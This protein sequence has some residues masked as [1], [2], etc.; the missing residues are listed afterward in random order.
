M[1]LIVIHRSNDFSSIGKT[2]LLQSALSDSPIADI[3]LDGLSR[4]CL[5]K[6]DGEKTIL[7]PEEWENK[8]LQRQPSIASYGKTLAVDLK[9]AKKHN[10]NEMLVLSNGRFVTQIDCRQM[11]NIV[12]EFNSDVI[13]VQADPELISSHE[14]ILLTSNENIAGFR[15]LYSSSMVPTPI[16]SD[17]PHHIFI[18]FKV[19]DKIMSENTLPLTFE[20]FINRCI[21]RSLDWYSISIGGTVLD[22]ESKAGLLAF[23]RH[24]LNLSYSPLIGA[25]GHGYAQ[26]NSAN[27]CL[28]SDSVTFF[29]KVILGNNV[30]IGK[31][32]VIVGPTIISDDV[33]VEPSAV[34]KSSVIG[35][36]QSIHKSCIVRDRLLIDSKQKHRFSTHSNSNSSQFKKTSLLFISN[37]SLNGDYRTW[38][39]FSYP[40]CLKRF[41]DIITSLIVLIL[42]APIFPVIAI[43]IKL[44]SKGPAFFK[45]RREGMHGKEFSCLKFRTMD[46]GADEI[47]N[48]LRFKNQSD[49]PQFKVKNDPR[50]TIVGK[51]MRN[52]FLDEI[53]QFI[54]VLSG[55]MSVV[56]PRPSPKSENSLCPAWRD[57]R[58][59]VR[60]GITGLWQICRT[61]QKGRDFQ[62][63]IYYDTKYVKKLSLGLDLFICWKTAKKLTLN[64]IDQF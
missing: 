10:A 28:V 16:S 40:C 43:V 1:H 2:C 58:L 41:A 24:S 12:D 44:N 13:M 55:Q 11:K 15:R 14:K 4:G 9:S 61:R 17:W 5:F 23:L 50:V 27:N 53:P 25:N 59:S 63:W 38:P 3:A 20:D 8:F 37:K 6:G 35:R 46:V 48:R 31:N 45:H 47:Q 22:L 30:S 62:E 51:F 56:G 52:T 49:G 34:I 54:N 29:D 57:A 26:V 7:I 32:A 60:P 42:F 19:L 21:S 39:K 18:K 64:F 33:K 36:G